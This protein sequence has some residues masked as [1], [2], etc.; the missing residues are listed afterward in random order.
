LRYGFAVQWFSGKLTPDG[1]VF[2]LP[3]TPLLRQILLILSVVKC[4]AIAALEPIFLVLLLVL[5][6]KI[7]HQIEKIKP[8]NISFLIFL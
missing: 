7:I 6:L 1:A 4:K 3:E 2:L 5:T 8:Q